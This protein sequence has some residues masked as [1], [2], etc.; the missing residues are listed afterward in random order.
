MQIQDFV[1]AYQAKRDEELIELAVAREQ[2]TSEARLALEGE[3]SRRAITIARNS[4][5][6]ERDEDWHG[7]RLML[8]SLKF[9]GALLINLLVAVIGTAVLD[10]EVRRAIPS[11][12]VSAIMWKEIILSVLC[13]AFLGF[14]MWRT[15]RTAAAKWVWVLP[16][17]WF[18][19]GY[20]AIANTPNVWGRF[21]G[22][23]SGSVFSAPDVRTFFAF[24]IPLIRAICYSIGAY[25]SA[26]VYHTRVIDKVRGDSSASNAGC[27][28]ATDH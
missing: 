18:A 13:A 2:L 14:F 22:F 20:L 4:G 1:K 8:R 28:L 24:T 17:M 16:A 25:I 21:S 23:S 7:F 15:W 27:D 26:M 19:F 3:L 6:S 11:H 10:T 9:C 5:A 12:S